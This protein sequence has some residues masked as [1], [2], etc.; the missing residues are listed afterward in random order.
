MAVNKQKVLLFLN[1]LDNYIQLRSQWQTVRIT[2]AQNGT[3][4][5]GYE[6]FMKRT[7]IELEAALMELLNGGE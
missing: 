4:V 1:H 6:A 7:R 3:D 5:A 2:G